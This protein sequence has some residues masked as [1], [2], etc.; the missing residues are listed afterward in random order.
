MAISTSKS[1]KT[2]VAND[3]AFC[4][5]TTPVTVEEPAVVEEPALVDE[6]VITEETVAVEESAAVE[7]LVTLEEP[8]V[9][10]TKHHC[11][12]PAPHLPLQSHRGQPQARR[13]QVQVDRHQGSRQ[14][15]QA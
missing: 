3:C 12:H 7:E 1:C 15:D 11:L 6:R 8:V 5:Y 10:A 2:I 9:V 13:S 14:Q 4:P